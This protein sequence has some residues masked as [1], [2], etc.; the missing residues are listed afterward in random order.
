MDRF[1]SIWQTSLSVVLTDSVAT[2]VVGCVDSDRTLTAHVQSK[3][4][5]VDTCLHALPSSDILCCSPVPP[6]SP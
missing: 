5:I 3:H 2:V 6:Q 1:K 4:V